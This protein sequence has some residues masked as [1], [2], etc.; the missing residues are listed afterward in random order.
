MPGQICHFEIGCK[1]EALTGK[2]YSGLFGWRT[3]N[4]H[5]MTML[6]TGSDV[7]GHLHPGRDPQNYTL[8]YVMVDDIT[9]SIQTAESLGGV[10]V[11]GPVPEGGGAYA[12]VRDPEGN[13][14]GIY[15]EGNSSQSK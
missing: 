11:L 14:I 15:Q 8:F 7:G 1:D 2:F 10:V 4:S 6:R 3:E 13:T 12:W 9:A 5:G